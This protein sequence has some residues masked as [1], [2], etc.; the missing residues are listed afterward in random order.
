MPSTGNKST[1]IS[2]DQNLIDGTKK[3]LVGVSLV[4]AGQTIT[5]TQLVTMLQARIDAANNSIAGKAAFQDAVQKDDAERAATDPVVA[6]VRKVLGVM[7]RDKLDVLSDFG[8]SP[9]KKP[10]PLTVDQKKAAAQ[11]RAATR[12]AR[13][14]L[15]PVQKSKIHGVVPTT[16]VD[17]TTA[18]PPPKPIA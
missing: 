17:P 6:D 2:R 4:V 1:R 16:P 18:Q 10:A 13:H 9:R 8:L 5:D 11:K 7:F 15:G 14:T 3:H 12:A